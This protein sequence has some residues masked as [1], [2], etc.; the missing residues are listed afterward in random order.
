MGKCFCCCTKR[1][2]GAE[3]GSAEDEA[4]GIEDEDRFGV[5][6]ECPVCR[7]EPPQIFGDL[8]PRLK[9]SADL[10]GRCG[11]GLPD[12]YHAARAEDEVI[13]E[14]VLSLWTEK[15]KPEKPV[16]L[17]CEMDSL[18]GCLKQ[19]RRLVAKKKPAEIQIPADPVDK[20]GA[21]ASSDSKSSE[22][23][24]VLSPTMEMNPSPEAIPALQ[25]MAA[26]LQMKTLPR[27]GTSG[28]EDVYARRVAVLASGEDHDAGGTKAAPADRGS[29]DGEIGSPEIDCMVPR[30][31][32]KTTDTTTASGRATSEDE[33]PSSASVL[34]IIG[35]RRISPSGASSSVEV[36]DGPPRREE[37]SDHTISSPAS[38][39]SKIASE[40][41]L[42][43]IGATTI[44]QGAKI[45]LP[46]HHMANENVPPPPPADELLERLLTVLRKG[47][48]K[49]T[50][51]FS[52]EAAEE[53]RGRNGGKKR[54]EETREAAEETARPRD[55]D[56]VPPS[57]YSMGAAAVG[58]NK[59]MPP[60]DRLCTVDDVGRWDATL[61]ELMASCAEDPRHAVT[62][63]H[64]F[65]FQDRVSRDRA[66][67]SRKWRPLFRSLS[68]TLLPPLGGGGAASAAGAQQAGG[69]SAPI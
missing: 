14:K 3:D 29:L 56:V 22:H 23:P 5:G 44:M 50:A 69:E 66:G 39:V 10:C 32:S 26:S 64:L 60:L 63:P 7:N 58:K 2:G 16:C 19:R 8:L 12:G 52:H 40:P 11:N 24:P 9:H 51:A 20:G 30:S 62:S 27:I 46:L 47:T 54:E 4:D 48:A 34:A 36:H 61:E 53:T 42:P 68:G 28:E 67:R 15:K 18:R 49:G 17:V 31:R 35:Q 41:A 25:P 45:K 38:V 55:D 33:S 6:W 65:Y 13:V 37:S 59:R 21:A 43:S 57:E 1:S